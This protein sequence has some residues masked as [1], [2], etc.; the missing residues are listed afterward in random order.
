MARVITA[1][2]LDHVAMVTAKKLRKDFQSADVRIHFIAYDGRFEFQILDSEGNHF[3]NATYPE[4]T[5][6]YA[7]LW[8]WLKTVIYAYSGY[9]DL[10]N[11]TIEWS[12]NVWDKFKPIVPLP[13]DE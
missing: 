10:S 8:E 13:F 2:V 12:D 1:G 9:E 11:D 5:F 4:D 7:D 3:A 6:D